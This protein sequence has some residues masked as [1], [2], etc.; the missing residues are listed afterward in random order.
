MSEYDTES[1][2]PSVA[3]TPVGSD[4]WIRVEDL[5]AHDRLEFE[6]VEWEKLLVIASRIQPDIPCS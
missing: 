2:P 1:P 4:L 5:E 6:W 3:A